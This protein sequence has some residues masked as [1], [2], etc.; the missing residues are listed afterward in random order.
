MKDQELMDRA[1]TI[2]KNNIVELDSMYEYDNV[3]TMNPIVRP[4]LKTGSELFDIWERDSVKLTNIDDD[5]IQSI[6]FSMNTSGY[7][8]HCI[9]LKQKV[10]K[11]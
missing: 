5:V 1:K 11:I 8:I 2:V 10:E 3:T 4:F 7:I 9:E 6:C